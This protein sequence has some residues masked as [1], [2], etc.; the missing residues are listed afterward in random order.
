MQFTGYEFFARTIFPEYQYA[1]ISF[2]D[3]T[4]FGKNLLSDIGV[5]PE[6]GGLVQNASYG[7]DT[8][9]GIDIKMIA[10]VGIVAAGIY[11]ASTR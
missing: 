3:L 2:C 7:P 9:G 4:D 8:V 5:A 10:I 11:Y 1:G 6:G